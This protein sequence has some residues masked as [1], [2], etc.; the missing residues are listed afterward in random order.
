MVCISDHLLQCN[1]KWTYL[2]NKFNSYFNRMSESINVNESSK[3]FLLLDAI[4]REIEDT[5][6]MSKVMKIDKAEVE[7]VLNGLTFQRLIIVEQKK[8]LFA[9][10]VQ[11]SITDTASRLIYSKKQELGDKAR[12]LETMFR[13]SDRRGMESFMDDKRARIPMVIFSGLMGATVFAS[14]MSFMRMTMNPAER[15][16]AGDEANAEAS[17]ETATPRQLLTTMVQVMPE[18]PQIPTVVIWEETLTFDS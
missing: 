14:M 4:S 18:P 10:N 13:N 6:K 17:S 12:V 15:A 7:I 8:G 1:T 11:V 3:H 2:L 5:G 9:K 16:M